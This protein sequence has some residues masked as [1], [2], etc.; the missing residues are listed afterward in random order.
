MAPLR[1]AASTAILAAIALALV[2]PAVVRQNSASLASQGLGTDDAFAAPGS[3]QMRENQI[4]GGSL[5][6]T[7]PKA[8]FVFHD[9]GPGDVRIRVAVRAQRTE[10][11]ALANGAIVG[12]LRPG[13]SE[14][15]ATL[16]LGG[17][18]LELEL[19][20]EGFEA[21]G[22]QLG[23]QLVSV[24]VEP[25]SRAPLPTRLLASLIAV[26][27]A[28]LVMRVLPGLPPAGALLPVAALALFALP[29]GLWRS[30][31]FLT[32]TV[33]TIAADAVALS[34]ARAARGLPESRAV[35]AAAL[36]A[37][38]AIHGIL[39]PSPLVAQGD[40]QMHGNKL[41]EVARGDFYPTSRTD[42]R[43]PFEIPYGVSFYAA[44]R[45]L[46]GSDVS[47][48]AVARAGSA[49][50]SALSLVLLAVVAG[51]SSVPF[52][53]AAV[54]LWSFAPVNLRTMGFGNLSNVFAQAVF[55]M[56]LSAAALMRPGR[57]RT[58]L[59]LA[60]ATLSATAHLSS[61]IVLAALVLVA[62]PLGSE[63]GA[64][65]FRALAGGVLLAGSYFALFLP[66]ILRQLP[67]LLGERGGSAGVFDPFRLPVQV[68]AGLG[69]PFLLMLAL[70][71][72]TSPP[73]L[74]LPLSRSILL[75]TGLLA[76]AALVSPVEVRYLL[77]AAPILALW[78][79]SALAD[80]FG[81]L[82]AQS[83]PSIVHGSGLRALA[84]DGVRQA[85]G[86][87]ILIAVILHG[88][89]V[90]LEFIPLAVR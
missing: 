49:F 88:L 68:A 46:A 11:L 30:P 15:A 62:T 52:A 54:L 9:V 74:P 61:F 59:M 87:M 26:L 72:W 8:R 16:P 19:R 55:V 35:L 14:M 57:S 53:T 10:V 27:L 81:A 83:A 77:A 69:A 23:A 90:L 47:N 64:A 2:V 75:T 5:R 17:D 6:W 78:G 24:E 41:G 18:D 63:R 29:A 25:A 79:A 40:V 84:R 22:R 34:V 28:G 21:G 33:L 31:W 51:R 73:R 76:V 42:H 82:P 50:F 86:A 85:A 39:A 44:L 80:D 3:L 4:G 32:A 12:S 13:R 71:A 48:V 67:R 37:G 45:P 89:R 70:S 56:F 38:L 43:P 60:L 1:A 36:F 58:L 20:T 65:G 66:L 7:R